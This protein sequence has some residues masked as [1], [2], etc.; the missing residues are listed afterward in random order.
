MIRKSIHHL[1]IMITLAHTGCVQ[2]QQSNTQSMKSKNEIESSY[3]NDG[4]A[5]VAVY[6]LEQNRYKDINE[7][8]LLSIF[9]TEDFLYD[10]QVKNDHYRSEKSTAVLKNIQT[11]K[12]PTGLYDYSMFSSAFTPLDRQTYPKTLKVSGSIQEWCGTTYTQLNYKNGAYTSTLH[13]YF[14]SE[15]DRTDKIQD[16]Y[17]EDG[18]YNVLRMNPDMLPTGEIDLIPTIN[19]LRLKHLESKAYK[20]IAAVSSYEGQEF[21]GKDLKVYRISTPDLRRELQIVFEADAPYSIV[22]WTD[23]YPSAFDQQIRTTKATL[24]KVDRIAYWKLNSLQDESMRQEFGL[25]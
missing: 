15:A 8:Q 18:L 4:K 3:W 19:V 10:K 1:V 22:G 9:V 12:F 17:T 11:R 5:E 6:H 20:S 24:K 25:K 13:S 23:S 16:G 21:Q 7:G 14:E 2:S